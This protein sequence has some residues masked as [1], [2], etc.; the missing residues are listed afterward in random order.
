[1]A[2]R[3][4][5]FA[6]WLRRGRDGRSHSDDGGGTAV[7]NI[8]PTKDDNVAVMD[9]SNGRSTPVTFS[10]GARLSAP[11]WSFQRERSL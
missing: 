1:M 8:K 11:Q 5:F 3:C 9:V 6:G 2:D 10:G 4:C 7:A